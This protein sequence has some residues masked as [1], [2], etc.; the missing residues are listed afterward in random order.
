VWPE[1]RVRARNQ[2]E[3]DCLLAAFAQAGVSCLARPGFCVE[4]GGAQPAQILRAVQ[5]CLARNAIDSVDVSLATGE[6]V[7]YR[8]D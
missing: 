7:L 2:R 6:Y 4:V 8:E 3:V 5:Q 1:V